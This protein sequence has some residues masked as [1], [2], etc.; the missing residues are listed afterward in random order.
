M[1][2]RES[3]DLVLEG[4]AIQGYLLIFH[5]SVKAKKNYH[6]TFANHMFSGKAKALL[7]LLLDNSEGQVLHPSNPFDPN[8]TDS[9]QSLY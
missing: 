6:F 3:K 8:Q 7:D 9:L 5:H 1:E 4:K 2:A